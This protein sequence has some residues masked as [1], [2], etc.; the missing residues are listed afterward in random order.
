[1][2]DSLRQQAARI[3]VGYRVPHHV[4]PQA[5]QNSHW[6]VA[7]PICVYLLLWARRS[8]DLRYRII[9]RYGVCAAG[10][11]AVGLIISWTPNIGALRFYWFRFGDTMLPLLTWF[12][13]IMWVNDALA[14]ARPGLA[15]AGM[16][17]AEAVSIAAPLVVSIP[18][19]VPVHA[20]LFG[21]DLAS[22]RLGAP[23]APAPSMS[24]WIRQHTAREARFLVDPADDTFYVQ[25]NRAVFVS[26]K[27]S[28]QSDRD[29]VE[30]YRR[31]VQLNG[32]REP[33]QRGP[34]AAV[35]LSAGFHKLSAAQITRIA[36][37][38]QVDYVV[39]SA[40]DLPFLRVHQAG[41]V[42]LYRVGSSAGPP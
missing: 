5:W 42:V 30:W 21:Q 22:W 41:G 1:L 32:E 26:F 28:P 27:H 33:V 29:I 37:D 14:H 11:F 3:Y 38:H 2:P 18:Y 34:A 10:L 39:T 7:L 24:V 9:A 4:L 19:F 17:F 20:K 25:A 12:L 8:A 16:R 15:R 6:L 13:V 23:A 36:Q 31:I 35:E 40:P